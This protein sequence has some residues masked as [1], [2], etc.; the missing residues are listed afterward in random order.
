MYMYLISSLLIVTCIGAICAVHVY[1]WQRFLNHWYDKLF[2]P[3]SPTIFTD[4]PNIS[5]VNPQ[6]SLPPTPTL[7]LSLSLFFL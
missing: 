4:N 5:D 7:S 1:T 2:H 3:T 6:T